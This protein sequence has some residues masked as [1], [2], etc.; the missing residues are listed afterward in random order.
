MSWN[1]LTGFLNFEE[2]PP[3]PLVLGAEL[4][5]PYGSEHTYLI[6]ERDGFD[7]GN[8]PQA[9]VEDCKKSV[10]IFPFGECAGGRLC[11]YKMKLARKWEN[12]EPQTEIVNGK[13]VIT[14]KSVLMCNAEGME[15]QAATSGQEFGKSIAE[16]LNL[17]AEIR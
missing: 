9:N 10:N 15:I 7:I 3:E 1:W 6:L 17:K 2:S 5:C 16:Q 11:E 4:W 12:P 13:E 8:L 14:T